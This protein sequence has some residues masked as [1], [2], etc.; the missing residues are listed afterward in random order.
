MIAILT[1]DRERKATALA[2]A[3]GRRILLATLLAEHPILSKG[4]D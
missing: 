2:E 4:L 3:V 1:S